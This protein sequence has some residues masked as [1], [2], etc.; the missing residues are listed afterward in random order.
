MADEDYRGP[1]LFSPDAATDIVFGMVGRNVL[2]IRPKPGDSARTTGDYASNY[3]GRVLPDFLERDR[4]SDD[5]D[6]WRQIADRQLR[7]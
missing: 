7:Y 3:K 6:V 4:R 2:G 5:E 1:V